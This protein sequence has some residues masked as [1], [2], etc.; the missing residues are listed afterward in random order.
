MNPTPG[1]WHRVRHRTSTEPSVVTI[2][3]VCSGTAGRPHPTWGNLNELP[4]G[5]GS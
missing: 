4:G 1:P 2:C 5:A 3:E